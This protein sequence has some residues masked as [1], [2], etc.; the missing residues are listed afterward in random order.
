[1]KFDRLV[2]G[3]MLSCDT[4]Q[5]LGGILEDVGWCLERWC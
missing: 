5:L 1:V 3:G 2:A 4:A